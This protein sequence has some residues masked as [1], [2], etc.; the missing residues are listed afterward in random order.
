MK[1]FQIIIIYH[2]ISTANP[3]IH[4]VKLE[5]IIYLLVEYHDEEHVHINGD[6]Q[7]V[8]KD[9]KVELIPFWK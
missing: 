5:N 8:C 6:A 9:R 4:K 2:V 1:E 7:L 3:K